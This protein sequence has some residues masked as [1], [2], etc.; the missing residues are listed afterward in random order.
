MTLIL[1]WRD[2]FNKEERDNGG[3][4]IGRE[5]ERERERVCSGG[6]RRENGRD[7]LIVVRGILHHPWVLY[8]YTP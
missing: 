2:T 4:E 5:R 3:G 6:T 1:N 7:T 8:K